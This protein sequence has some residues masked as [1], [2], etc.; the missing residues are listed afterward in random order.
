MIVVRNK[1]EFELIIISR[2]IIIIFMI[3]DQAAGCC[4]ID[5]AIGCGVEVVA[6]SGWFSS[7]LHCVWVIGSDVRLYLSRDFR[8]VYAIW[9]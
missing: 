7:K 9:V 5:E 3:V 2:I 6:E 4:R 8:C 1:F